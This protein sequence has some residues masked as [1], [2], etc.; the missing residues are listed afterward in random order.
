ML[1][2]GSAG[3]ALLV[4]LPLTVSAISFLLLCTVEENLL[5]RQLNNHISW[6]PRAH[7]ALAVSLSHDTGKKEEKRCRDRAIKMRLSTKGTRSPEI[8]TPTRSTFVDISQPVI[9]RNLIE[10]LTEMTKDMYDKFSEPVTKSAFRSFHQHRDTDAWSLHKS[11]KKS[12]FGAF[13]SAV[14]RE[15]ARLKERRVHGK[16]LRKACKGDE[17]EMLN[18]SPRQRGENFRRCDSRRRKSAK[19]VASI[20]AVL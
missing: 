2:D 12:P 17:R 13:Y 20:T 18:R 6:S 15:T 14:E 3:Q 7:K 4:T 9:S 10:Y 16:S 1:S 19:L 5:Q 8:S 11:C